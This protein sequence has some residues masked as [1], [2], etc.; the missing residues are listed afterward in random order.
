MVDRRDGTTWV[1]LELTR[2]GEK[3]VETGTLDKELRKVLGLDGQWPIFIP[4]RV[5]KRGLKNVVVHLMEGYAFI[6]SGLDEVNYFRLEHEGKLVERVMTA[7][8]PSGLRVLKTIPDRQVRELRRQLVAEVSSDLE[9]NISVHVS[10][11]RYKGLDGVVLF[12][13]DEY[14]LVSIGLRSMEIVATIPRI[15]LRADG[16][17]PVN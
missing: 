11:G 13:E 8:S 9:P 5:Y 1:A 2:Q 6:A 16:D 7:S 12:V 17:E 15:F 3:E 10:D 4:A 14:A